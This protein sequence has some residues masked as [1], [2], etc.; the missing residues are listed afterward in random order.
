MIGII[1]TSA[2]LRL[3][4]PD[5]PIPKGLER[6]FFGVEQGSNV[7]LAPELLTA[8]AAN[9]LN[10]KLKAGL[11]TPEES[12]TLLKDLLNMPIHFLSH[13]HILDHAMDVAAEHHLTVYDALFIALALAQ[14]G[15][16]FSAD[17]HVLKIARHLNLA[18]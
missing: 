11:L 14:G 13:I 16:L 8:E 1:D 12:K 7:A 18:A 6:F 10:K 2:L 17:E 3:F 9:V 5:G 4:I 15:V